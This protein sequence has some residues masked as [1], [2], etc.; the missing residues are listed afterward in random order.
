MPRA[1]EQNRGREPAFPTSSAQSASARACGARRTPKLRYTRWCCLDRESVVTEWN[2]KRLLHHTLHPRVWL[3]A[4]AALALVAFVDTASSGHSSTR[5]DALPRGAE[6]LREPIRLPHCPM[7][8]VEWRPTD[9]LPVETSPSA[10]A[11]AVIDGA[12]SDAFARYGAFLRSRNLAQPRAEPDELPAISVLPANIFLDGKAPRAL[13]DLPSR[14]EA[15]APGGCCFWGL[16]VASLN[17]L[18][19]RNDPLTVDPSGAARANPRFVRT[20]TH[21]ISHVLS[22]HL[23]VWSAIPYDRRTDEKLAEDFV[24]FMGLA[25]EVESSTED[26]ALHRPLPPG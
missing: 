23:G 20:L 14:F 8:I 18:F 13:N 15:V 6:R 24:A 10:R 2:L 21:E 22:A 1:R 17:H 5:W 4:A 19:V 11:L 3:L 25:S 9:A 26:L 12:C 7:A 16:Y